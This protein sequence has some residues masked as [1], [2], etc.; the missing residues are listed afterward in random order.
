MVFDVSIRSGILVPI[1]LVDVGGLGLRRG[2]GLL[3]MGFTP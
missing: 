3:G 1:I 2:G